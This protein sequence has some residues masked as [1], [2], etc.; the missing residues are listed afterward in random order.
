MKQHRCAVLAAALLAVLA[1]PAAADDTKATDVLDKAI[2]AIGGEA[3]LEKIKAFTWKAKGTITL[4]GSDSDFTLQATA[5]GIEHLRSEFEGEFGGMKVKG[6][7]VVNGDKGWRK[8]GDM[9]NAFDKNALANEKGNL[10][11]TLAPVT[12]LPLKG[13]GFKLEAAGEE[14]VGDKPAVGL[15][16]TGPGGED[17]KLFFDKESG[18]PVKLVAKVKGL[19]GEDA[20]QETT[21]GGWK[22]FDGFKKATKV[23]TKRDGEKFMKQELTEFKILSKV[24]EK[25]FAEP[26]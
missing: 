22:D 13:K 11:R 9:L 12:L 6:L 3:K 7:T 5:Q 20:T 18:L 2:K 10:Y 17:F 4:N 21:F 8:F 23:E 15:K 1:A 16:V 24:D 19:M 14:K 25:T 26:E